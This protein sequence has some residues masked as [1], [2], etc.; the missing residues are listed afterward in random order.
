MEFEKTNIQEIDLKSKKNSF[1]N[2]VLKKD[3]FPKK[4]NFIKQNHFDKN[5]KKKNV[6]EKSHFKPSIYYK[7]ALDRCPIALPLSLEAG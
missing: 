3:D 4:N 6:F 1:Q 7:A 5:F 2:N